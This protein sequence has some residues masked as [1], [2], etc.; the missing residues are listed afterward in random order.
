MLARMRAALVVIAC[1]LLL[2][3][4]GGSNPVEKS[5]GGLTDADM[6]AIQGVS[7]ALQ[8]AG[9]HYTTMNA[10][11]EA[12]N[13]AGAR[14]SL[15]EASAQLDQADDKTIDVDNSKL[16]TALQ[17]YVGVTRSAL[18]A[19]NRWITYYEDDSMPRDEALENEMLTDIDTASTAARKADQAFLNRVLDEASP[20]QRDEI[21]ARY[22]QATADEATGG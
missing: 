7:T 10:E 9:T 15:D 22:R 20:E 16:R 8:S 13:V 12:E 4:C 1:T 3:G 21:R 2:A 14:T 18:S 19:F 11:L 5:F 6:R 17:D